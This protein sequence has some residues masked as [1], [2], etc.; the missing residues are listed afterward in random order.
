MI[1]ASRRHTLIRGLNCRRIPCNEVNC[2]RHSRGV[3]APWPS[4]PGGG[5]TAVTVLP[6]RVK[7]PRVPLGLG[8][9]RR[10]FAGPGGKGRGMAPW[11]QES[12]LQ[13][14]RPDRASASRQAKTS[15]VLSRGDPITKPKQTPSACA[16]QCL[17]VF[18]FVWGFFF[19][20]KTNVY[21]VVFQAA[22]DSGT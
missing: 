18:L 19:G 5:Q 16:T 2:E 7:V 4:S 6:T 21:T 15:H 9:G 1:L 8:A 12:S 22:H 17:Q 10:M 3:S 11:Q 20:M 14:S 13:A